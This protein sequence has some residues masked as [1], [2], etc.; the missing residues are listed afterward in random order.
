MRTRMLKSVVRFSW[1]AFLIVIS[2]QKENL[3]TQTAASMQAQTELSAQDNSQIVAVAQDAMNA[4]GSALAGKGISNG[5]YAPNERT[6]GGDDVGCAPSISGSF[7]I[8]RT[9]PDSTIYSG[10]LTIDYGT[11]TSCK[12]ST[13]IRRGKLID[14]FKL[15]VR[16]KDSITYSLTESVTFQGYQLDSVTVDG[17]FVSVSTSD[18]ISTLTIQNAKITYANGTSVTWGGTLTNKYIHVGAFERDM[19]SREVTGSISGMNRA[20][21]AFSASITKPI[22]FEYN[23]S[24]TIPVSGTV[25]L[26]VGD[27]VSVIDYG[28]GVCDKNYTITTGG[29]TTTYTFKRHHHV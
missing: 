20:G 12:D 17:S 3:S 26:T 11:G 14:A 29:V 2:C 5:R 22:W 13:E 7:A 25:N 1:L 24:R 8:D 15:I 18:A 28:T 23:C 19:E 10:T 27:A 9:H 4:T 16:V 6:D 21:V